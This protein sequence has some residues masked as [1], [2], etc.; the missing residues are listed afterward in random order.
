MLFSS[1]VAWGC[2]LCWCTRAEHVNS[3][4]FGSFYIH[5]K[6]SQCLIRSDSKKWLYLI[7][8]IFYRTAKWIVL[9]VE[10]KTEK[11]QFSFHSNIFQGLHH[12]GFWLVKKRKRGASAGRWGG[13][14][15]TLY[16]TITRFLLGQGLRVYFHSFLS[17]QTLSWR[18]KSKLSSHRIEA[19]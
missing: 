8:A 9:S 18:E 6:D 2:W 19:F 16:A 3:N 17:L 7:L 5:V 4:L 15:V 1:N 12:V 13:V 10:P 11:N 14:F